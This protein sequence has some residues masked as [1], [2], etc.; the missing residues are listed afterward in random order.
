[1]ILLIDGNAFINVS[2]AVVRGNLL[3]DIRVGEQ[4]WVEDLEREGN[5]LL[6]SQTQLAF[7][8][9]I[10]SYLNSI[11]KP[12]KGKITHIVFAFDSVS[13]RKQFIREHFE[14][15]ET[16]V[17]FVYKGNRKEDNKKLLF[18]DYFYSHILPILQ[19]SGITSYRSKGLEGDDIIAYLSSR[20]KQDLVIWSVDTDLM[21]LVKSSTSK[22]VLV[23]PKM[24]SK[25][26]RIVTDKNFFDVQESSNDPFSMDESNFNKRGIVNLVKDIA[27]NSEYTHLLID[28]REEVLKKILHGDK[29][30]VI[31]R[32]H[33]KLSE[34]K[35]ELV[36]ELIKESSIWED[37]LNIM[38]ND[39]DRFVSMVSDA[40]KAV[41]SIKEESEMETLK[42]DIAVR[43]KIIR[44]SPKFFPQDLLENLNDQMRKNKVTRFNIETFRKIIEDKL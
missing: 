22:T 26:K 36:M 43:L 13:W 37:L 3:K 8:K 21:Q 14:V 17:T 40:V 29:S 18:F 25:T 4:Y 11:L 9:F 6:K 31:K 20:S 28:P 32:A 15:E 30:D 12:F 39:T 27:N 19:E 42:K 41:L 38:E 34:K 7:R 44:L 23:L 10:G 1:M 16:D 33:R 35:T 24:Q 5:F 2:F